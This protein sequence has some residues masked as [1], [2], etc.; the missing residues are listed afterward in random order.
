MTVLSGIGGEFVVLLLLTFGLLLAVLG[1]FMLV[2]SRGSPRIYG[3]GF[4]CVGVVTIA[5]LVLALRSGALA[6]DADAVADI[7]LPGV[8]HF[9]GIAVGAVLAV[10][11]F[12]IAA[13]R[14]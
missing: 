6:P 5:A 2:W 13:V 8:V 12:I 3:A 4:L 11:L 7:I 9:L 1:A 14:S 10:L